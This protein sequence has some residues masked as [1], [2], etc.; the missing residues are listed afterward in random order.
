MT[1]S[2]LAWAVYWLM[3]VAVWSFA[4]WTGITT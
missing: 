3:F 4:L 1:R 2:K